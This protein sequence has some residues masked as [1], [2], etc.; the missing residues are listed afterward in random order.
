MFDNVLVA[1]DGTENSH[2][3]LDR[4]IA[5][6]A[7]FGGTVHGFSVAPEHG[8]DTHRD[9]LRS[10]PDSAAREAVD[11]V[12][13]RAEAEDLEYVEAV[14]HGDPQEEILRYVRDHPVDLVVMGTHGR[15]GVD[16]FLSGSVAEETVRNS[17]VPVLVVPPTDN[18]RGRTGDEE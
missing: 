5:I 1:T 9:Q 16:R 14:V 10:D 17:N 7:A 11:Q 13:R 8:G 6:A 15:S 3:A 18:T 4:A 2:R 12:R